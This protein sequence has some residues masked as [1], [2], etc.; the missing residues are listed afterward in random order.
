MPEC[1][2]GANTIGFQ[3]HFGKELFNEIINNNVQ[4]HNKQK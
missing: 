3:G 1:Y 2:E 4:Y